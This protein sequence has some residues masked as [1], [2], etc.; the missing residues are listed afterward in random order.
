M[1]DEIWPK[2]FVGDFNCPKMLVVGWMG[3]C[4]TEDVLF[5]ANTFFVLGS[6]VLA[7]SGD[8]AFVG[9]PELPNL[10]GSGFGALTSRLLPFVFE[11]EFP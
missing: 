4:K 7:P 10:N 3:S 2:S 11:T 1:G 5:G 9:S 8:C 6:N